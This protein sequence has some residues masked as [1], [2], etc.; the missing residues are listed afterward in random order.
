MDFLSGR[1][2]VTQIGWSTIEK[3]YF[4]ALATIESL[5]WIAA[6]TAGFDLCT[7]HKNYSS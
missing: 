3:E 4:A 7:Y 5:H 6:T 2:N 1:L